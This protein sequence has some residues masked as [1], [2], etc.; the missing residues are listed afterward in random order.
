MKK[1]KINPN[2]WSPFKSKWKAA[3]E[4]GL[5][6]MPKENDYIL[7]LGASAGTTVNHISF[8]TKGLIFAVENSPQMATSLV[9]LSEKKKNIAP[10]FSDARDIGFIKRALFNQKIDVL[11]QDIPSTDQVNILIGASQLVKK[12]CKIFFSLKTQSISQ[13]NPEKT[14]TEVK[15]K[16]NKYFKILEVKNLEPFHK[17]HY[18]FVLRKK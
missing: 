16:L 11:F 7:Y 17:K 15:E 3:L 13:Q 5:N 1:P 12:E 9:K 8:L 18:F 2:E 10:I 4:K 6:V 14:L